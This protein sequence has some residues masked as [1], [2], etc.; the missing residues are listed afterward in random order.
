MRTI[1][2]VHVLSGALGLLSGYL[3]LAASKGATLHRRIGTLFVCMMVTMSVTGLLI[4]AV[5]GVAPAINVPTAL[6]T[7]YLVTT[8]VT[9]VR[10]IA[11]WSRQLDTSAMLAGVAIGLAC[12]A[13]AVAAIANG[14]RGAALAY[15]L[16]LFGAIACGASAGDR[17]MIRAGGVRGKARLAR[18]LWR[19]CVGLF[20]ASIAFYLGPDRL[21]EALSS[22]VFRGSGLLLP[23]IAMLY[24]LWK[25][26]AR[27]WRRN[28]VS[29]SVPE[30]V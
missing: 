21:P 19:M 8:A 20:I 26:R 18:H 11:W 17:R 27:G 6:L 5:Q 3:A 15:P 23:L 12:L 10:P 28:I 14:G 13:L 22:P 29:V 16:F 2:S 25:L 9:T 1:L 4:S 7:L 30:A 24:W